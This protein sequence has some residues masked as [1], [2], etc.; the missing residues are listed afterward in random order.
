MSS[1]SREYA[2]VIIIVADKSEMTGRIWN[3]SERC[4]NP[5]PFLRKKWK[6]DYPVS[7]Q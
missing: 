6:V 7:L 4:V 3:N 5:A 2:R 1:P